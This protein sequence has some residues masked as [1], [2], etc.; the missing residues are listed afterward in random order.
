MEPVP[1]VQIQFPIVQY[2]MLKQ[3]PHVVNVMQIISLKRL[4]N[5]QLVQVRPIAQHVLR[6]QMHVQHV[7]QEVIQMEPVVNCVVR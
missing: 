6:H 5:V 3:E 4:Q 2:V 1:I 7:K